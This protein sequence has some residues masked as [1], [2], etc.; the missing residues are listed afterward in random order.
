MAQITVPGS[1]A[2]STNVTPVSAE[3]PTGVTL[4]EQI[5]DFT[6]QTN[7]AEPSGPTVDAAQ[8][9]PIEQPEWNYF[10]DQYEIRRMAAD[11]LDRGDSQKAIRVAALA[12]HYNLKT[13]ES[14]L[15]Q[16]RRRRARGTSGLWPSSP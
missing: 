7:A 8:D 9:L 1:T 3:V 13:V 11:A 16:I 10:D 6:A 15:S 5:D 14:T 4:P 2:E 12:E